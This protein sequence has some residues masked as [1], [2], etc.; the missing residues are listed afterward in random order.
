MDKKEVMDSWKPIEFKP[1][2]I[3]KAENNDKA[4][5][6]RN[7]RGAFKNMF[8]GK[9]GEVELE[10][11]RPGDMNLEKCSGGKKKPPKK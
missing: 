4:T 5:R 6:K 9:S 8:M 3:D 10:I 7:Y 2:H 11:I 1:I